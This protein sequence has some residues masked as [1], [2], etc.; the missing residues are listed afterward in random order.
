MAKHSK[1]Q[2]EKAGINFEITEVT[3]HLFLSVLLLTGYHELPDHKIHW[4]ATPIL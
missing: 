4:E 3:I 1:V 2:P